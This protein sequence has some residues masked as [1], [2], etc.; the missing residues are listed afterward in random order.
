M[1]NAGESPTRQ[2]ARFAVHAGGFPALARQRAVDAITD[3]VGCMLAGSREALTGPLLRVLPNHA[4]PSPS[5]G[6]ILVGTARYATPADAALF[7]GTAAHALDYDDTNHPSYAHPS[8]VI[9]PALLALAPLARATGA[10]LVTAYILGLEVFGK[11]GRVLNNA[12]YKRGWHATSTF[13]TLAAAVAAGRVLRL[14]EPQMA[15]ALG[16]AASTA[17]GLRANFG[18]MVKPLHAG[19]AACN[20]VFAALL[21]REGFLASEA[22]LEH[23]YGYC[24]VFSASAGFDLTPFGALGDP[25][26]ILTEYGLALKMYPACGATHPGIE[27]A[28]LL[29]RDLAGAAI[30]GVRAGVCEMAFAPLI[31][32]MPNAPLEGKFSLHFCLAAALVDGS[33]NLATFTDAKIAD[34]RIRALIPKIRM[35]VD[36]RFRHG[37]EFPT[38]VTVETE[39]GACHERFV[40]LAAGKPERWFTPA[41]LRDKFGDCAARALPPDRLERAFALLSAMDREADCDA[42]LGV[43]QH[44]APLDVAAGIAVQEHASV[45]SLVSE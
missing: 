10:E 32:V 26:E 29:H 16:I 15:M 6:A 43:L 28:L 42:L 30:R 18:T 24:A 31:Y 4:Q 12:H 1:P 35:E 40:P 33:V 27:A 20:G 41:Q 39:S 5:A 9:V 14:D 38:A 34:P 45:N 19:K 21:A 25:L 17:G 37:S 7:N 44:A 36:E 3:C 11:L 22:S 8:A 2:L 23:E 13:G